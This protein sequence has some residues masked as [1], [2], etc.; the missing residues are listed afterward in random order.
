MRIHRFSRVEDPLTE[1]LCLLVHLLIQ[2]S[3][4]KSTYAKRKRR[5]E[6][7]A[8]KQEQV[9]LLREF[10]TPNSSVSAESPHNE[11][12]NQ[13]IIE[14]NLACVNDKKCN[15]ILVRRWGI[16]WRPITYR[17]DKIAT[18]AWVCAMLHNICV[19][20][21]LLSK[22]RFYVNQV[23]QWPDVPEQELVEDP[24]PGD[25]AIIERL[26]NNYLIYSIFV[27]NNKVELFTL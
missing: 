13:S 26:P 16:L 23:R 11:A 20:R 14:K 1:Q 22:P 6:E 27:Y 4:K 18:I 3:S 9:A 7:I 17:L 21:W 5:D 15:A 25:E 24:M 10:M 12:V 8:I 19:D 2:N